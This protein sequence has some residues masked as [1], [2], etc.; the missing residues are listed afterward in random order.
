MSRLDDI[1]FEPLQPVDYELLKRGDVPTSEEITGKVKADIK[2]LFL[3]IIAA[4]ENIG[5]DPEWPWSKVNH[6]DQL[7]AEL[8]Q[9]VEEL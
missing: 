4:N 6:R 5:I 2:A 3:E 9:K 7:R 8:R 1:L